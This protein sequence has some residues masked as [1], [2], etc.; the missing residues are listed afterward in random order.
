MALPLT[1]KL[2]ALLQDGTMQIRTALTSRLQRYA[3]LR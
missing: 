3:S 1:E 2:A